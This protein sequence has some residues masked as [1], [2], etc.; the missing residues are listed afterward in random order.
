MKVLACLM[1][2]FFLNNNNIAVS[3]KSS[4]AFLQSL[5]G[6]SNLITIAQQSHVRV[7]DSQINASCS[8]QNIEFLPAY[9][10]TKDFLMKCLKSPGY[11]KAWKKEVINILERHGDCVIWSRNP[12]IGTLLFTCIALD[13]GFKVYNHMCANILSGWSNKKYTFTEK[14]FGFLVSLVIKRLLIKVIK[15]ENTINLCTG[16]ILYN[17]C[18]K[19]NHNTF[20]FV[21]S[22]IK[23]SGSYSVPSRTKLDSNLKLIFIGRVQEDKGIKE[24]CEVVSLLS[25]S[26]LN[27][28]LSVIGTGVLYELLKHRYTGSS[29]ICF[30]GHVKNS[31]LHVHLERADAVVVPSNNSYEGF[32]RVIMEAWAYKKPVIVSNA[33][34]VGAFVKHRFNGLIFT[35]G[36]FKALEEQIKFILNAGVY[37]SL[38]ENIESMGDISTEDYWVEETKKILGI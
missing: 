11:Y 5:F 19:Y 6:K 34:G 24:L 27:I 15:N 12:S 1:E 33:G 17:F 35:R 23:K 38:V 16:D 28:E 36:D 29:E 4:L 14:A 21:D 32:P 8:Q 31:S 18:L 9:S 2:P 13:K 10:S 20:Q 26:G 37:E 22:T 30:L 25:Y 3:N 7:F